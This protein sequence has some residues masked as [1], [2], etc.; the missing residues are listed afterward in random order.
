MRSVR[1]D[2]DLHQGATWDLV[3]R[4]YNADPPEGDGLPRSAVGLDVQFQIRAEPHEGAT[5]LASAST[6]DGRVT[7]D[8]DGYIRIRLPRAVTAA[9]PL[10]G[11]PRTWW[12]DVRVSEA[13]DTEP[14]RYW[15]HGA[16]NARPRV[17]A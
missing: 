4:A 8:A 6:T 11:R 9:L 2:Q 3:L 13:G 12:Y 5:L 10:A 1:L 17:T 7:V 16:I 15:I 14:T